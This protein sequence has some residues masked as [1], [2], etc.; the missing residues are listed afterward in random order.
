VK[1]ITRQLYAKS[2]LTANQTSEA[3]NI[4]LAAG[5]IDFDSRDAIK[6]W[7]LFTY[8]LIAKLVGLGQLTEAME[9]LD[10][11][12]QA[13]YC[14]EMEQHRSYAAKDIA[15]AL[16]ARGDLAQARRIADWLGQGESR[17]FCLLER[18][19]VYCSLIKAHCRLDQP[20]DGLAIFLEMRE[21]PLGEYGYGFIAMAIASLMD[22]FLSHGET[23]AA[24]HL[25]ANRPL[26]NSADFD[27]PSPL[28]P[29]L[30][31]S[32]GENPFGLEWRRKWA[33]F[34][35]DLLRLAHKASSGLAEK[36]LDLVKECLRLEEYERAIAV[37][38]S[39]EALPLVDSTPANQAGKAIL[40]ALV[41]N[42]RE[43]EAKALASG[44][45][46]K[47]PPPEANRFLSQFERL[48]RPTQNRKA[49]DRAI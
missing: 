33:E 9:F 46:E 11:F 32:K 30:L 47:L 37:F 18:A 36:A 41:K 29:G 10:K 48:V 12:N 17:V 24:A 19:D 49:K 23:A 4:Y 26:K 35:K 44:R 25:F 42:G 34:E 16:V 7:S 45:A 22:T 21:M 5:P 1:T 40:E 8:E 27:N 6:A 43:T 3:I 14:L 31:D 2:L 38:R 20:E 13:P 28:T 15:R 39:L